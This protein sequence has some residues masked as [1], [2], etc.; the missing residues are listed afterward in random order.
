M[1]DSANS[2]A[3]RVVRLGGSLLDWAAWPTQFRVWLESQSPAKTML[4]VGGG[5]FVETIRKLDR[6]HQLGETKSHWLCIKALRLSAALAAE[7]LS[8][9]AFM[10]KPFEMDCPDLSLADV[11][12]LMELDASK[13]VRPLPQTWDV[14]SDS[15]AARAATLF[16]ADELVL[17][18]STL[19]ERSGSLR[20]YAEAGYVDPHFPICAKSIPRIRFVNLR[21]PEFAERVFTIGQ[22][23]R[24]PDEL[25][26]FSS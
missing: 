2:F 12:F 5:Q 14:T 25:T 4:L 8:P 24:K 11:D 15:I 10:P 17:L 3:T 13:S 20:G 9:I 19:P 21:H 16:Q 18:K 6:T 7:L 1:N 22:G 23:A 26:G